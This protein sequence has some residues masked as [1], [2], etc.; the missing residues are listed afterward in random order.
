MNTPVDATLIE[1]MNAIYQALLTRKATA[2][3]GGTAI[4]HG[5]TLAGGDRETGV[6]L[7]HDINGRMVRGVDGI[8][9]DAEVNGDE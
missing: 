9:Y 1:K 5:L 3:T 8:G 7:Y 4:A 2:R 6:W